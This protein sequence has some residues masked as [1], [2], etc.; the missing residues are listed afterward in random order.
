[1]FVPADYSPE[2]PAPVVL[3]LHGAGQSA[4]IGIRPFLPLAEAAGVVLV[5][6]DSRGRTWDFLYGPYGND[7]AFI[8][9]AL[10]HAFERCAIDPERVTI[11]GFSDG[12][13][14]ALSLG[15]TNGDL[16]S[17]VIAFSPCIFAPAATAGHPS[18]FIS[19]GTADQILPIDNCGRRLAAQLSG[20]G[21]SVT[22]REFSGP[23]SVP[24]ETAQEAMRWLL[25]KDG[26]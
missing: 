3:M 18:I 20:A 19:H 1:M 17:R 14:Y 6:P 23:H 12:A 25:S 9:R 15:V 4:Q 26:R 10:S 13:S 16:F 11:E 2:M 22:Y 8:D 21:Y 7:V 5:A 24:P